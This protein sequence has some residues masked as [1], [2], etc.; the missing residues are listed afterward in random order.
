MSGTEEMTRD[1][2]EVTYGTVIDGYKGHGFIPRDVTHVRFH[3][4]VTKIRNGAFE[5]RTELRE[6][7]LNDDLREI[8][9]GAFYGCSSLQSINIPSTITKIGYNTFSGCHSL[10]VVVLNE[11]LTEIVD[12]AFQYCKA[13]CKV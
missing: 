4:S 6:V 12:C 10:N 9:D 13:H 5:E 2:T 7:I 11:G 1:T 3:P 8:G